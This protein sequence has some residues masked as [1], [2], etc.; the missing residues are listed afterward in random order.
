MDEEK[1]WLKFLKGGRVEDYLNFSAARQK[2]ELSEG[3]F[4]AVY[5]RGVGNQGIKCGGERPTG[6]SSHS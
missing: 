6:D 5:N 4:H 2:R 1:Y 3:G